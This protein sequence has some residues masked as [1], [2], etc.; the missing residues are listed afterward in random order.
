VFNIT[1][2]GLLLDKYMDFLVENDFKLVISLDGNEYNNSYRVLKDGSPS[3]GKVLENVDTLKRKY[4]EY[5]K[6]RTDFNA[7]FHNRN[8]V[9][10]VYHFFKSRFDKVPTL[11][12]LNPTGIKTSMQKEFWK[13]YANINASLEQA[14]DYSLIQKDMFQRLP[15]IDGVS[16]FIRQRSGFVFDDYTDLLASVQGE[17]TGTGQIQPRIPTGTC[18]PFS[19]KVF[20]TVNGGILPC[21]RI[22]HQF[23]LGTADETEVD[24][25]F[26]KIAAIY[27]R[28]LDKITPQC[29]GCANAESCMQCMFY[30]ALDT[31]APK[32][33]GW[34]DKERFSQLLS[35]DISFLEENPHTYTK[36]K[37]EVRVE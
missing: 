28:Y 22:G 26:D 1:T 16:Q 24:L 30:L 35:R 10:D 5:F 3:F 29:A 18:L 23:I 17:T 19:R 13:T 20:I 9:S 11:S 34:L 8:S 6:N 37:K 31:P 15:N 25:D 7:V 2:N 27:N 33:T 36:I 12:E 21:E 14:E 32:C 4:P